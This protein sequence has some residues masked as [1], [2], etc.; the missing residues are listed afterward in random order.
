M[1]RNLLPASLLLAAATQLQAQSV[2]SPPPPLFTRHDAI[3][4]AGF[5]LGSIA[6]TRAD[7]HLAKEWNERRLENNHTD[8]VLA[9]NF[10]R[11]QEGTL[12][13]GNLGLWAI[14]RLAHAPAMA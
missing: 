8:S 3:W 2:D 14:A 7:V 5:L 12:T 4:S 9:R 1:H 6:L 10:A 13:V 11:V